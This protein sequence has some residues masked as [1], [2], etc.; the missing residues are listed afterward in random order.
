MKNAIVQ[1]LDRV[2]RQAGRATNAD[3]IWRRVERTSIAFEWGRLKS[4]GVNEESGIGLRVLREGKAGIAGSTSGDLDGLIARA[5]ESADLGETVELTFPSRAALPG[6]PTEY[7]AARDASLEALIT[8]GRELIERL[9]RDG[10]QVNVSL[11]R[12]L[13]ETEIG[14][15]AGG[16]GAYRATGVGVSADVWR[17]SGDD[18]LAISESL[19]GGDLPD[20]AALDD[21]VRSITTRLDA[22]LKIVESPAGSLPVVFTP[23]GLSAVLLPI[24][25]ALSGKAVLQGISPLASKVGETVFDPAFSIT[26]NPLLAG[27]AS[28]RPVDDEGVPSQITTLVERGVVKQFIYDLETAVRSKTR[29][30]GHG[31]R[32]IFSKPAP[33]YTNLILGNGEGGSGK[34]EGGGLGGGLLDGIRDGLLVDD[35]IGVGQG[36]VISGAFSHPV[37][38]AY[39]I[40]NGAIT[41]RV[42]DAAVAGNA[43]DLLKRI[44]GWGNDARWYGSRFG[45]SLLLEGVSVAGR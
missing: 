13:G 19:E 24:T 18:V 25:Q 37:A 12:E 2:R 8:I 41:G 38:L 1:L 32:G 16:E 33:G 28:S 44:A 14:N 9:A 29:S 10:V 30:T 21:I 20:R 35:L 6:V 22:A 34:G 36:N 5:F 3:A 40:S 15:S 43:Y 39:R 7:A 11:E 23:A 4:A 31:R 27:R 17:V 42:K 26:D 45:P